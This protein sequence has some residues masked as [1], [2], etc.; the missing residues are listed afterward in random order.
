MIKHRI[1][2]L[3]VNKGRY[4]SSWIY[5]QKV[6]CL[7]FINSTNRKIFSSQGY[8]T[9]SSIMLFG[10]HRPFSCCNNCSCFNSCLFA[11]KICNSFNK[12]YNKLFSLYKNISFYFFSQSMTS[13]ICNIWPMFP[14]LLV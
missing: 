7:L 2:V 5:R 9:S 4:A 11:T 14:L 3:H 13:S 12:W 10:Y 8:I 6:L 1:V